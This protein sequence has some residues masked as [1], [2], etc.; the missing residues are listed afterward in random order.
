MKNNAT[1]AASLR[2]SLSSSTKQNETTTNTANNNQKPKKIN[3]KMVKKYSGRGLKT[4]TISGPGMPTQRFKICV[5]NHPDDVQKW[6]EER[7][8]RF[9]RRDGS[10]RKNIIDGKKKRHR[11]GEQENDK[12]VAQTKRTCLNEKEKNNADAT[13]ENEEE[14]GL[15][16]LL[17][18]YD[19]S[20]SQ[21]DDSNPNNGTPKKK[22]ESSSVSAAVVPP[23]PMKGDDTTKS[24]PSALDTSS[25][26]PKQRLCKYYQRGKCIH[27]DSCKFLHSEASAKDP[28]QQQKQRQSQSERDKAKNQ[29]QRELQVL[30]LAT[31]SHGNRYTP[32]GKKVMDSSS[33]LHKLLQRDKERER[34]L[35]LQLLRY[36][37]DCDYFQPSSSRETNKSNDTDEG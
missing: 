35:T 8:K 14:G 20:S 19:S 9:P 11:E 23:P 33:L 2:Q 32:G 3:P 4:I 24:S 10:H 21:E 18:G 15:S 26:K 13:G 29:Y 27:G 6:I 30:G 22:D 28:H 34:R 7:K 37:V 36:V 17:A 12:D 1:A 16:S 5:G 25:P 31:P